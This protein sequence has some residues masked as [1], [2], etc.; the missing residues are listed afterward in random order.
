MQELI[1]FLLF[2]SSAICP[3][4]LSIWFFSPSLIKDLSAFVLLLL[5]I[6]LTL[7]IISLNVLLTSVLAAS[8]SFKPNFLIENRDVAFTLS[9]VTAMLIIE[10]PLLISFL[11]AL[12]LKTFCMTVIGLQFVFLLLESGL[13]Q[14]LGKKQHIKE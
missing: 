11:F 3:G 1:F 2:I 4:L 8:F 14:H 9:A 10:I 5:S 6:A 13:F 7:P 12:S